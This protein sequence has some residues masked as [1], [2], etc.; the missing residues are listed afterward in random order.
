MKFK[1]ILGLL[2]VLMGCFPSQETPKDEMQAEKG[3][4]SPKSGLLFDNGINRGTTY[5]D[6]LGIDFNLRY[7]PITIT[8][9]STI[10]VHLQIAFSRE[11]NYPTAETDQKFKV[12]PM[13]K[14]WALDGV[15]V[16]DRM[17]N[18]LKDY[19]DD[20][21]LNETLE[22]GEEFVFAIGTLYPRPPKTT[23][24]LPK[25]LFAHI[26][27]GVFFSCD[28]LM[29]KEPSLN[30]PKVLGLKLVFGESCTVIPCG[31]I[32]YSER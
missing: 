26:D 5:R 27:A 13:P 23:G 25:A 7:I 12:I 3:L 1:N 8:N 22:S 20:P 32:S 28:W 10:P 2:I 11:Y 16:T 24:V 4:M 17:F 15:G 9:D 6:T 21:T 14:E 19:I 18:E 30:P 29:K 31:Q